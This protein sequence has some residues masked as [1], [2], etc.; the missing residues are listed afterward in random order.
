MF[1]KKFAEC[2]NIFL[3]NFSLNSTAYIDLL[4]KF[5]FC[6]L[7]C[8]FLFFMFVCYQ[9]WRIKM[10]Y[11]TMHYL[12][13]RMGMVA[14]QYEKHRPGFLLFQQ[15][16]DQC[17]RER[18]AE[19][20]DS[21]LGVF[22]NWHRLVNLVRVLPSQS[23]AAE[24]ADKQRTTIMNHRHRQTSIHKESSIG[25]L[26]SWDLKGSKFKWDPPDVRDACV[27]SAKRPQVSANVWTGS[28]TPL[29]V[30]GGTL[31]EF[32]NK[33]SD[34]GSGMKQCENWQNVNSQGWV[35]K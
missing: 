6:L 20:R 25:L 21:K 26:M 12:D 11:I 17:S 32:E 8:F 10:Y 35:T 34:G 9:L 2:D 7:F 14:I 23:S 1:E 28:T 24:A 16:A 31:A 33:A 15:D 13:T 5:L 29:E 18:F 30:W 22:S 27:I 3:Q 19:R 4:I